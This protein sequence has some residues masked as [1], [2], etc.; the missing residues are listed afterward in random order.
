ML[1][2]TLRASAAAARPARSSPRRGFLSDILASLRAAIS[3]AAPAP[4]SA[5][6]SAAAPAPASVSKPAGAAAPDA[7]LAKQREL[8]LWQLSWVASQPAYGLAQHAAMLEALVARAGL[9]GLLASAAAALSAEQRAALDEQMLSVRIARALAPG[10]VAAGAAALRGAARLRLAA[11]AGTTPAAV[12]AWLASYEQTRAL[13]GWLAKRRA[14]GLPA[15]RTLEQYAALVQQERVGL[16]A[17]AG[18]AQKAQMRES[19]RRGGMRAML[20]KEFAQR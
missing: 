3:P 10:E 17:A 5:S 12:D 19:L 20:R 2:V 9:T 7:R 11:A 8:T 15:P 13:A 16:A 18:G 6:A 1:R 4:A 14:A